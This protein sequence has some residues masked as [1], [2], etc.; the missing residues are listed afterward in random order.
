[1]PIESYSLVVYYHWKSFILSQFMLKLNRICLF[2]ILLER[3][4]YLPLV[5]WSLKISFQTC[6]QTYF[7]V[8]VECKVKLMVKWIEVFNINLRYW[9]IDAF[10]W[11]Y[12]YQEFLW[13]T[14]MEKNIYCCLRYLVQ[15]CMF[16]IFHYGYPFNDFR[17]VF[18][19]I[20][21]KI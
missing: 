17:L 5:L 15:R 2:N 14:C 1:M 10:Y 12:A 18:F 4:F 11:S 21:Y 6:I 19:Q 8:Y 16:K 3:P 7:I 9:V 20:L 13:F